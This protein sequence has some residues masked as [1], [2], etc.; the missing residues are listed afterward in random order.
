MFRVLSFSCF[1]ENICF[2]GQIC[3]Y[4]QTR[5]ACLFG[6]CQLPSSR[7]FFHQFSCFGG[8]FGGPKPSG[9]ASGRHPEKSSNFDTTFLAIL[10]NFGDFGVPPGGLQIDQRLPAP[11]HPRSPRSSVGRPESTFFGIGGAKRVFLIFQ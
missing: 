7:V 6:R 1:C 4:F 3:L 8:H 2:Q 9:R 11:K 5:N 10:A